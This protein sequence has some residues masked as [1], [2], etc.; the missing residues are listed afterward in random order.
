MAGTSEL[1]SGF[2]TFEGKFRSAIVMERSPA[3][4]VVIDT[5]IESGM[6]TCSN[7]NQVLSELE[8]NHSGQRSC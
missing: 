2:D 3:D 5:S 4:I 7:V 8:I 6:R 1:F